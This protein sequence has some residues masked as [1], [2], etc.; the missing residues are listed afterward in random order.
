MNHRW[1]SLTVAGSLILLALLLAGANLFNK[2][3]SSANRNGA[4]ALLMTAIA[5][6]LAVLG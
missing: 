2:D 6:A 1:I 4:V 5:V 3:Q